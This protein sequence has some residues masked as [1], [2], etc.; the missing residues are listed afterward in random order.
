MRPR[1][2]AL[3]VVA[4]QVRHAR[5]LEQGPHPFFI[6]AEGASIE[7]GLRRLFGHQVAE[8]RSE[9]RPFRGA[10]TN[11][12]PRIGAELPATLDHRCHQLTGDFLAPRA[13]G[14]GQYQHWIDAAHLGEHRDGLLPCSGHVAKGTAT[15]ERAGEADGLNRRVL[16]QRFTDTSAVD[17]VE[18]TLGHVGLLGGAQDRIGHAFGGCHVPAVGLEHHRATSGQGCCGIAASSRKGQRK[19]AGAEHCHRADADPVLAQVNP[20]QR[21]TLRQ[22]A[23]DARAVEIAPTQ[24]LSEQT[25]LAAGAA[26]LALN[27]GAGQ[28]G[29]TGHQGN[30]LVIQ[31]IQLR[32]DGFKELRP[33]RRRQITK[34]WI[35]GRSGLDGGVDFLRGGLHERV[36][37]CFAGAGVMAAQDDVAD[38]A[39]RSADIVVAKDLRHQKSS[40]RKMG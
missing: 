27:P 38:G 2:I 12:Q 3:L 9:R 37:Q 21:L 22:G 7:H 13:Q 6:A 4:R 11:D 28:G 1:L 32:G 18:H 34:D 25:H 31:G 20:W 26:A 14:F 10:N 24:D 8:S 36:G 29:L 39:A 17:H 35:G 19:I 15:F 5:M 23:V 40:C 16:D 33:A 30:E